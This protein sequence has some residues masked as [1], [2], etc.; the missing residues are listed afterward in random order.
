MTT[1]SLSPPRR[2]QAERSTATRTLLLDAAVVSLLKRGYEATTTRGVARLAG[3]SQGAQQH[4]F[5]SKSALVTAAI[6]HMVGQLA[7]QT[8]A[9]LVLAQSERARA[10]QFIDRLW[11][12]HQLPL[13]RA[14]FGI[15][16]R[17]RED[18]EVSL[19]I[20]KALADGELVVHQMI[21][22]LVPGLSKL[23]GFSDWLLLAEALMRGTVLITMLPGARSGYAGWPLVRG[24]ILADLD[25]RILLAA[26]VR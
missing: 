12:A 15:F 11:A 4:H 23:P 13:A 26:A 25:R 21:R 17:A 2:T 19:N 18:V 22:S 16:H 9:Q 1:R 6:S 3:V 20:A 10:E 14:V 24:H 5:P 7:E 8:A